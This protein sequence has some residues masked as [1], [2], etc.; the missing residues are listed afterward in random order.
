LLDRERVAE[1]LLLGFDDIDPCFRN[2]LLVQR[3]NLSRKLI[4][5][6]EAVLDANGAKETMSGKTAAEA[7][8]LLDPSHESACRYLIHY[9]AVAGDSSAALG[10]YNRLWDL[11]DSEYDMEPA[12][13][14]QQLIAAVKLGEIGPMHID[15][16]PAG[17]LTPHG[18]GTASD[19]AAGGILQLNSPA[20]PASLV[21]MIGHFDLDGIRDEQKHICLGFRSELVSTLTRF[22]EWSIIDVSKSV[23]ELDTLSGAQPKYLLQGRL[24]QDRET[25]HLVLELQDPTSGFL[26]WSERFVLKLGN[27]FA[28]QERVVRQIAFTLN[29]HISQ[30][31][32]RQVSGRPDISLDIYDRWL[33]GHAFVLKWQPGL[34]RRAE[35]IFRSIIADSPNFAPAYSSLVGLYN[36]N[37]F[38]FA[39]IDQSNE[40]RTEALKLAKKA[41]E[42][43]PLDSRSQLHL[44]WS[45]AM[46]SQHGNAEIGFKLACELNEND[47]W[48]I[49]SAA[50]G[51]AF[52]G[53]SE[54][55]SNYAERALKLAIA[56]VPM[57][58]A[59][60]GCVR[61]I[62]EDYEGCIQASTQSEDEVLVMSAWKV[63]ALLK[64]G[65]AAEAKR[66]GERLFE[67]IHEN[68]Q[69]DKEPTVDAVV[70]WL[71]RCFPIRDG[72]VREDLAAALKAP[73]IRLD[74]KQ[75]GLTEN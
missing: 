28:T 67:R 41:V 39:G 13:P 35:E 26:I 64:A 36:S 20:R 68:W 9:H 49:A 16:A 37:H 58:W 34:R 69:S 56:P 62:K 71:V 45:Q 21:M 17:E 8:L 50:G 14:T 42:I 27:Y 59:Y 40:I 22:R 55:A 38:V 75:S 10:I 48:T 1:S 66:E 52:C 73:I 43:D 11:L 46:N 31:R 12:E 72:E 70:G 51:F 7:L 74:S 33:R 6:L 30:E 44:A 32:L 15:R 60:V 54:T 19:V 4:R 47:P 61:Y 18:T 57:V 23:P 63:A 2:W 53:Q 3:E 65:R 5:G 29:V 24:Y 25:A